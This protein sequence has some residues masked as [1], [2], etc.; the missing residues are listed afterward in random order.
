MTTLSKRF[1]IFIVLFT[2]I[3]IN[4]GFSRPLDSP[5]QAELY[6]QLELSKAGLKQEVFEKAMA[7][8]NRL[9][10][11]MG[12]SD[13]LSIAD[14][15]QS[16][17]AKRLY[18]IDVKNSRLLYQTY[19]AHGRNSGEEYA[20]FFSN[21]AESFQSSPGFYLTGE[22]YM[23]KHGLSL[24][25]KGLEA[26]INDRAEQRAI[27][28]HGADYVSESFIHRFGRLGRSLGCPA[29]PVELCRPI[30]DQIKSGSCFFIYVPGADYAAASK[31]T[32]FIKPD[33]YSSI[34]SN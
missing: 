24:Q 12:A 2:F 21:K 6:A 22:P 4:F 9:H 18:I 32:H 1:Y 14:F 15:S 19:V 17:N 11:T 31:L 7:G 33:Y 3:S 8:W 16:S 5:P 25:L 26:G 13:L 27:V 23:G 10:A 34:G 29:V 28:L 20:T 30:I